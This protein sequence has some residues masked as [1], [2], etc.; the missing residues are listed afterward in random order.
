M[1]DCP[2][3]GSFVEREMVDH[4]IPIE[5]GRWHCRNCGLTEPEENDEEE[6][7]D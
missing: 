1:N 2:R 5:T 3:C 4:G 7:N 6:T